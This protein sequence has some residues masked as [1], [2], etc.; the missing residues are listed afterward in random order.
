MSNNRLKYDTC[1]FN[2]EGKK[3]NN[4]LDYVMNSMKYENDKKCM[5]QFGLLGGPSVS[6]IKGN[7]IDLESVLR[8]LGSTTTNCSQL[9]STP[10]TKMTIEGESRSNER[11]EIDITLQHLDSCQMLD[12]EPAVIS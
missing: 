12:F 10:D 5:H 9:N 11:K 1:T 2:E 8:G 6:E 4:S 7:K 3:Y